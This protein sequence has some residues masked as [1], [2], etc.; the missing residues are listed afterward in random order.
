[1]GTASDPSWTRD[2]PVSDGH[3][4]HGG[5]VV[6]SGRGGGGARARHQQVAGE[7]QPAHL[8]QKPRTSIKNR[9]LV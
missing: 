5:Y 4:R 6:S 7:P 8:H 1:M 9:A 2:A 3:Q